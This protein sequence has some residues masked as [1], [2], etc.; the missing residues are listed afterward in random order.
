LTKTY[1]MMRRIS[2]IRR[3][4]DQLQVDLDLYKQKKKPINQWYNEL[5][6]Y[7]S[8]SHYS[9]DLRIGGQV[10]DIDQKNMTWGSL[11]KKLKE[12]LKKYRKNHPYHPLTNDPHYYPYNKKEIR[13]E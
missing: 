9:R 4:A 12:S 7:E 3:R 6:R 2:S 13:N 10:I 5:A 11:S 8:N 1:A